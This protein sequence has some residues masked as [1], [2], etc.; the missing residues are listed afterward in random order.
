MAELR[1]VSHPESEPT[2]MDDNLLYNPEQR[3]PC[4][5]LA[6]VSGSMRGQ[7][8][9]QLNAGLDA[10]HRDL[11]SDLIALK[12]VELALITFGSSVTV[13]QDFATADQIT[14][15]SGLGASGG[16]PMGEAITK[17]LEL[18]EQRKAAYRSHGIPHLRAWYWIVSD[19]G[20]NNDIT[21]QAQALYAADQNKKAVVFTLGVE[22]ADF[23]ML[24][25]LSPRPPLK[26]DG[27]NFPDIF[28]W[29]SKS[30]RAGSRSQPGAVTALTNPTGASFLEV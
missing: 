20:A 15:L 24:K 21:S 16:T 14:S 8:I 4:V 10:L 7:R 13:K 17:G 30:L 2:M 27:L 11:S 1:P 9:N 19:G 22:G 18:V 6:D 26:L 29:L 28:L 5:I 25:T 12:R 23:A 3:I